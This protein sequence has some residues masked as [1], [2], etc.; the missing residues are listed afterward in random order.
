MMS[1]TKPP[2]KRFEETFSA[3]AQ[4]RPDIRAAV[5][6][7]SQARVQRPADEWADLDIVMLCRSIERYRSR[8]EWLDELGKVWV[9]TTLGENV[10]G[11]P[12]RFAL[13][14]G[15]LT[16]DFLLISDMKAKWG[17][18]L[19]RLLKRFPKSGRLLPGG[20]A[21]R[22]GRLAALTS[23]TF[24][25][26][27]RVLLDKDGLLDDMR[28]VID[29]APPEEWPTQGEFLEVVNGFWWLADRTARKLG[30][31]ELYVAITYHRGLVDQIVR[32]AEWQARATSGQDYDTWHGGRFL[33]EWADPR[34][35]EGLRQAFPH[36]NREDIQRALF[37]T[38][39]LFRW[40]AIEAAERL[41]YPYPTAADERVTE[42]I[43]G[44]LEERASPA[45]DGGG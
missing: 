8:T 15:G 44:C 9:T 1:Q 45:Q 41:G 42:W 23:G 11:E 34:A 26:G 5:V 6:V 14:E 7:G 19:L 3:W 35:V 2:V 13:F 20:L 37:A 32:M 21:A 30:R 12:E 25:R 43:R 29:R 17:V 27:M 24:G 33:E 28:R 39:D 38:M 40:L 4:R 16:V 36:C 18:R 31:G 10:A 22:F